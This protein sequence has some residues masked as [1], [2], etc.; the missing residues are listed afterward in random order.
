MVPSWLYTSS[1]RVVSNPSRSARFLYMS[2]DLRHPLPPRFYPLRHRCCWNDEVRISSVD[3]RLVICPP[4][5]YVMW[6]ICS[7]PFILGLFII[8]PDPCSRRVSSVLS[9]CTVPLHPRCVPFS[10]A[11]DLRIDPL[12]SAYF[13]SHHIASADR[14]FLSL[15]R[16]FLSACCLSLLSTLD[17]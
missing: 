14:E 12:P 5:R 11:T 17:L 10:D 15:N 7:R 6:N 8:I 3:Q 13:S 1:R 2:L 9:T 16:P 4:S